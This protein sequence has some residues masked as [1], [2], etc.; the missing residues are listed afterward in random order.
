VPD[1]PAAGPLGEL[2]FGHQAR[3]NPVCPLR[4][5]AG[6]R[7]VERDGVDLDGIEQ[8]AEFAAE[9]GVPAAARADL[10]GDS[11]RTSPVVPDEDRPDAV[12]RPFGLREPT[13]DDS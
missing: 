9:R 11:R 5:R 2:H 8:S 10:P 1:V 12:P 6:R 4:E 13:D 3:L 7:Q